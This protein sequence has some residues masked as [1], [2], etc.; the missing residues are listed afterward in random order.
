MGDR[1]GEET[2]GPY[3]IESLI[4]RG[5]MGEVHRAF[6]TRRDRIV[7]L[8]RLPTALAQD[9]DFRARFRKEA[10]VAARL[11]EPHIV[12]IHDFGEIDGVLFIDM[13]L[14]EG[15]DLAALLKRQ[16]ALPPGRAV[17]IVAQVAAA[18]DV[19]HEQGL[20]HRDIKPA[21]ILVTPASTGADEFVY[22]ADFGIARS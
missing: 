5:G 19:A 18:L 15:E 11:H 2:F 17:N 21:N 13:R 10:S 1:V 6:D 3:R 9:E 14:V 4:G 22:V 12:P 7:A 8:K 20:V 16:G